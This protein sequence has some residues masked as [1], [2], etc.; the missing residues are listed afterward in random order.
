[1]G[2]PNHN[3]HYGYIYFSHDF[4]ENDT[5]LEALEWFKISSGMMFGPNPIYND[6]VRL[7]YNQLY[8]INIECDFISPEAENLSHYKMIIAPALYSAPEALLHSL[9][10]FVNDGGHL[11]TSFKTAVAN[12]YLKVYHDQLPH[13]LWECLGITYNQ[14]TSAENVSITKSNYDVTKFFKYRTA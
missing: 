4:A 5:Y 3:I 13:I 1:M 8:R 9:K 6:I 7:F 11:V 10:E 2:Y 12:E 14:F